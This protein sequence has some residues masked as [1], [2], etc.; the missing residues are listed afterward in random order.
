[1]LNSCLTLFLG[2]I[3]CHSVVDAPTNPKFLDFSQ[4]D[5]YF[6]LVKSFFIFFCNFYK[7]NGMKFI[8]LPKKERFFDENGQ[9]HYFLTNIGI[10]CF[11]YVISML[12]EIFWGALHVCRSKI[13]DVE[14][15]FHIHH[16]FESPRPQGCSWRGY[17]NQEADQKLKWKLRTMPS[18]SW[19]IF[20]RA[21]IDHM[22]CYNLNWP[23]IKLWVHYFVFSCALDHILKS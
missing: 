15:S 21:V 23:K 13:D 14:N 20:L 3:S 10:F 4:F 11:N 8:F 6:H 16:I 22:I 18:F 17:A 12:W 7:K 5:P 9:K 1:M 19:S 2:V